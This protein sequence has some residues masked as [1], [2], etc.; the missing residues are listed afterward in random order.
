VILRAIADNGQAGRAAS[1]TPTIRSASASGS[2]P[3]ARASARS[4]AT[5]SLPTILPSSAAASSLVHDPRLARQSERPRIAE[6][7]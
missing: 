5:R 4:A 3:H 1:L 2:A 6:L 7:G